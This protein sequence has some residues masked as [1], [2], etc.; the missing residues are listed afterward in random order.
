MKFYLYPIAIIYPIC[1]VPVYA[2]TYTLAVS[3]ATK[4]ASHLEV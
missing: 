2:Y 1:F 4:Q 3:I